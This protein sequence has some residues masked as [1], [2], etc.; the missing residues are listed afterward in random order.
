MD[1]ILAVRPDVQV[2][3]VVEGATALHTVLGFFT[4]TEGRYYAA[5]QYLHSD[6]EHDPYFVY[7]VWE[8]LGTY[9]YP[10]WCRIGSGETAD[11]I[12][13]LQIINGKEVK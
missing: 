1:S 10:K 5:T 2:A 9:D 4:G 7:I 3:D 13:F 8:I 11:V 6:T 12:P